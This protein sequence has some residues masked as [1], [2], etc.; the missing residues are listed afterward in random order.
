MEHQSSAHQKPTAGRS[1]SAPQPSPANDNQRLRLAPAQPAELSKPSTTPT[2]NST[3]L[4]HSLPAS[5][6]LLNGLK[7][8]AQRLSPLLAVE[9]AYKLY[10]AN[11][12]RKDLKTELLARKEELKAIK[13]E[14]KTLQHKMDAHRQAQN[15]RPAL[16]PYER[17]EREEPNNRP[18]LPQQVQVA[19]PVLNAGENPSNHPATDNVG[20][21]TQ[22]QS[23]KRQRR[24]FVDED[25]LPTH[26]PKSE[27]SRLYPEKPSISGSDSRPVS[28]NI[29]L[30]EELQSLGNS[31]EQEDRLIAI[32]LS[33]PSR[34]TPELNAPENTSPGEG[35]DIATQAYQQFMAT[36][37]IKEGREGIDRTIDPDRALNADSEAFM[38]LLGVTNDETAL[39][40]LLETSPTAA[41]LSREHQD[42]YVE[43]VMGL[44]LEKVSTLEM[45][46]G[47]DGSIVGVST[48]D[49]SRGIGNPGIDRTAPTPREERLFDA[50]R[51]ELMVR[52][53]PGLPL[54]A[55][56]EYQRE[57]GSLIREFGRDGLAF[58]EDECDED[59]KT[60]DQY[61][62]ARMSIG[63][64]KP[65]E[66]IESVSG[67][68]PETAEMSKGQRAQYTLTQI[69]PV[70]KQDEVSAQRETINNI[71]QDAQVPADIKRSDCWEL[72]LQ[73]IPEQQWNPQ[74]PDATCRGYSSSP[75]PPPREPEPEPLLGP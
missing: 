56:L 17:P 10:S 21:A 9:S 50:E 1:Q 28:F 7:V 33:I 72:V 61:I 3:Q 69:Q 60:V 39:Q 65:P 14:V 36:R 73:A 22:E 42:A 18:I 37:A 27:Q 54:P 43:T 20:A 6:R 63:G 26:S 62:A 30:S 47:R 32:Y 53:F 31:E 38:S 29:K 51:T 5:G 75:A 40:T 68:S 16:H 70:F 52:S 35:Q 34:E 23:Q 74:N 13:A 4:N 45:V 49:T 25:L 66:I 55:K 57:L 24:C 71:R 58:K 15:P 2:K 46:M 41:N 48:T 44:S 8:G 12:Q 19:D 64:F 67:S 11:E 59:A